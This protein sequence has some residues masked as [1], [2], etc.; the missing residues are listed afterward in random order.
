MV[1]APEAWSVTRGTGVDVELIDTGH[2]RGH[3]DLPLVPPGNCAGEYDGCSD[4][5][6]IPHGTHVLG[7]WTARD[8]TVG[9]VG[10]APGINGGD[11]FVYGACSSSTGS[12]PT[13]YVTAGINSAIFTADV[14]N[15][16]LQ[17]PW[18]AAQSNAIA[19]AWGNDIVIVAAAG[20]NLPGIVI[21]PAGYFNVVGVSGVRTDGTFASSSP[22]LT[23]S[24]FGSHVDLAGPFW[25]LSTVPGGYEDE[26]DGWCGTSMATPHVSGAA[27]LVR[28]QNPTWS[29]QQV[30]DRLFATADDR[31]ATGR[32]DYYG[33]GIVDAAYA[34]GIPPPPP[35]QLD[36]S[37]AGPTR[38]RPE[39]ICSWEAVVSGGTPPYSYNWYN[40]GIHRGS[41]RY[42]TGGKDP[43][44]MR[45]WFLLRVDVTDSG[46]SS[47]SDTFTVYEDES[48]MI[49]RM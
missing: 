36:V 49:C 23:S 13:T 26:T 3:E 29:N 11:V 5:F 18:D 2:D 32:D 17:Q 20:N 7:I 34:V 8:N 1:R 16:S 6:P 14:I 31:G 38:I 33:Y 43:G 22:C 35:V 39:A 15:L 27:A 40:D 37:I 46:S 21:Y 9:V 25:A 19:Q 30:V 48:A 4:A 44:S 24:N 12:C 42:Y 28:A 41:G 45:D 10:V 47:G